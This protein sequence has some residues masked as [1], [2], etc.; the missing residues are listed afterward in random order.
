MRLD[1]AAAETLGGLDLRPKILGLLPDVHQASRFPSD[2]T[3]QL[4]IGHQKFAAYEA[5]DR[6]D[7]LFV[8]KVYSGHA[9]DGKT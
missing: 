8:Q 7:G 5:L 2:L 4:D 6:G 1:P 9:A 3:T